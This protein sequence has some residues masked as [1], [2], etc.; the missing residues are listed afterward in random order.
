MGAQMPTETYG[1]GPFHAGGGGGG[2]RGC[3]AATQVL[4]T[5]S[6]T[7]P[8]PQ[9]AALPIPDDASVANASG[10]PAIATAI[11]RRRNIP[12]IAGFSSFIPDLAKG[13]CYDRPATDI[14]RI[15]DRADR[16]SFVRQPQVD[17]TALRQPTVDG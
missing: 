2:G 9:S 7:V 13:R 17:D 10:A 14:H 15:D 6:S 1:V 3:S 5:G 4:D 11:A 8:W 16:T 12:L